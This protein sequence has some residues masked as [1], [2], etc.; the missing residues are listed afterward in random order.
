MFLKGGGDLSLDRLFIKDTD[1]GF[2]EFGG[3]ARPLRLLR[4]HQC[5]GITRNR[6]ELLR[7]RHT[8]YASFFNI[9]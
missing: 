5:V 7:R 2:A 8:I 3:K 6:I 4:S 1:S 9:L